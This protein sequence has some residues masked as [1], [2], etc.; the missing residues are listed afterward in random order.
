MGR[1]L[2]DVEE[3]LKLFPFRLAAGSENVLQLQLGDSV[4]TPPE[5]SAHVLRKLKLDAEEALGTSVTEAVITVPAYFNDTQRQGDERTRAHR[6][7]EVLRLVNEPT[8]AALAT[9]SISAS[10]ASVAV[11]DLGGGTFDIS[12]LRLHDGIFEVLATNGDTHLGGDD[13]DNLL[14]RIALE[15]IQS[16]W[17]VDLSTNPGAVQHLRRAVIEA[18][19]RFRLRPPRPCN[20][21]MRQALCPRNHARAARSPD[22]ADCRPDA[23]AVPRLYRRRGR[24]SGRNRRSSARG[25]IDAHSIG[26]FRGRE[27]V[28]RAAA[29]RA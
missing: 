16:E 4:M 27:T 7:L 25:R 23:G 21:S 22:H 3:E 5:V 24:E 26:P 8:A 9:G 2:A 10:K 18:K 6:G 17:G 14:L 15:D 1:G 28:P 29:Y 11:Y 12:I 19:K 20:W 13:I